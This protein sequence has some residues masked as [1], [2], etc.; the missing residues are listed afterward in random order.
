MGEVEKSNEEI[1]REILAARP[2]VEAILV[3]RAVAAIR[4]EGVEPTPALI[5]KAV[6]AIMA[7]ILDDTASVLDEVF[8][9]EEIERV[10]DE[11]IERDADPETGR[12]NVAAADAA[13]SPRLYA[14]ARL[15]HPKRF[16][17]E[18]Q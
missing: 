8:T 6:E 3:E 15:V 1:A 14:L 5:E 9:D 13:V 16:P 18:E 2:D 4:E 12:V 17:K 7:D 11:E 10:V